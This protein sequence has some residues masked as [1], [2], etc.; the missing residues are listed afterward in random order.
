MISNLGTKIQ[1]VK[2][3]SSSLKD[4][5]INYSLGDSISSACVLAASIDNHTKALNRIAAIMER[6]NGFRDMTEE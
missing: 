6:K 1:E 2:N 3:E 4:L 5:A